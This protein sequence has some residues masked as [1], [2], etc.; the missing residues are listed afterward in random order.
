MVVEPLEQRLESAILDLLAQRR[1]DASICPSDAARV[2]G[3]DTD[4]RE[5]MD[6]ARQ[7]AGRLVR[8][9][10]VRVTQ[11]DQ[12]VDPESAKGPIRIRRA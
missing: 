3:S 1:P 8:S 6:P 2:V 10:R 4:W 9:G 7:A 5:L 11:G 12:V